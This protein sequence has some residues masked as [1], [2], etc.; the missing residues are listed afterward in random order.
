[1]TTV[2]KIEGKFYVVEKV[3]RTIRRII[4]GPYSNLNLALG[5]KNSPKRK[6]QRKAK[7][8]PG[9]RVMIY[10]RVL[11]IYAQKTSGPYK[12]QRFY[13]TFKPGAVMYGMPDGSLKIVHP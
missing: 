9:K 5:K 1:M 10:G 4:S 7:T 8:N 13:H 6:V 3:G 11:K 12:G 2:A